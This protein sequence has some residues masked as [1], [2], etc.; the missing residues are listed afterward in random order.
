MAQPSTVLH[1]ARVINRFDFIDVV[2][3]HSPTDEFRMKVCTLRREGNIESPDYDRCGVPHF[4][5]GD[6]G[7]WRL[8]LDA[9]RLAVL[10]RRER[11]AVLHAHHYDETLIGWLATRASRGSVLV[12]GRHYS[13]S[14]HVLPARVKARIL[15]QLETWANEAAA[16]IIVP[17]TYVKEVL[18]LRQGVS[19][20]KI[21]RIPYG[22]DPE[23]FS[24]LRAGDSERPRDELWSR[25]HVVVGTFG[26]LDQQKGHQLLVAALKG[27]S[28]RWPTLRWAVVGDGPER[29]SLEALV[30]EAGLSHIT[31]FLGWRRDALSLMTA[32]DIVVQPTFQEAFSQVMI[33][34]LWLG[35]PVVMTDVG[36]VRDL[37]EHGR[38]GLIV[39]PGRPNELENALEHL[40]TDKQARYLLG[41]RGQ[42]AVQARL[43]VGAVVA[44]HL[45]VYR[46][47]LA[48]NVW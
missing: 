29:T 37:I 33:E 11:V 18:T 36:G 23:K 41:S 42:L 48:E 5:L 2:V 22:V 16:R 38:T 25:G 26:R 40:L 14:L 12:V 28:R 47:A 31:K 3:R 8:P 39:P 1:F 19:E 6:H 46:R 27:L 43:D 45:S 17:S 30:R 13:D 35:R 7:R 32:V 20:E 15:L 4:V 10:L 21:C 24:H 44:Q 9:L 34:A